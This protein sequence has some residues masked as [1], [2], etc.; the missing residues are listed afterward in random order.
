MRAYAEE[1]NIGKY[2]AIVREKKREAR[3]IR[4]TITTTTTT[5]GLVDL[6]F[7]S[8]DMYA[9]VLNIHID[10]CYDNNTKKN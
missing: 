9:L 6:T 5:V 8:I 1:K 2:Q 7:L 3:L 10:R 4:K